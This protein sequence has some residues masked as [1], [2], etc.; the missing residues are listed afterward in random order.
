MS[1]SLPVEQPVHRLVNAINTLGLYILRNAM[2]GFDKLMIDI[3]RCISVHRSGYFLFTD[4]KMLVIA[5]TPRKDWHLSKIRCKVVSFQALDATMNWQ[6]S[7]S[8]LICP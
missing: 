4:Q 7:M 1:S 2:D 6:D 8:T 3:L 5:R